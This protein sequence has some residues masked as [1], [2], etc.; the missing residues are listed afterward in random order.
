MKD[1][2][3]HRSYSKVQ[4]AI[5]VPTTLLSLGLAAPVMAQSGQNVVLEEIIVSARRQEESAQQIPIAITVVDQA[6]MSNN[7]V[8]SSVDLKQFTPSLATN[9][10]FGPDQA[11]FAIR[12][13][14]QELRTTA[15]VGFYFAEVVAPRGGGSVTA[16]DGAGPGAFFDLQNVLVLKGP[17]GTLFGRNTTGGAILLTPQEPT[18]QLEG[19]LEGSAGDYDMRRLQGVLNV[20]FSDTVRARFGVDTMQRDGYL[21][22]ISGVGPSDLGDTDYIS[23]RASVIWEITDDVEN[24]TILSYTDSENNG[25]VSSL[26]A[27]GTAMSGLMPSECNAQLARQGG[28]FYAVESLMPNPSSKLE[29]WQLINKTSWAINDDLTF[30]NIFSY[31]ELEQT[32][33]TSVFGIAFNY[34]NPGAGTGRYG[35]SESNQIPGGIPTNS[36]TSLVEEMQLQGY[37]MD[38]DLT[39]QAG[40]YFENSRPDGV[41]GSQSVNGL[42]CSEYDPTDPVSAICGTIYLNPL[43]AGGISRQAGK[44][45]YTTK[46]VYTEMTYDIT[47]ELKVTAGLRYTDDKVEGTVTDARV[48][49]GFPAY[50]GLGG[51]G[52]T[53]GPFGPIPAERCIYN[54]V[55]NPGPN[56]CTDELEQASEAVTGLIGVD[57]FVTQDAMLYAKYS[58]GY[59]M[60][61]LNMFGGE[62][63]RRFEPETVDAFEIGAKTT[64]GGPMPG[65]FNISAFYNELTDQQLQIGFLPLDGQTPT[66]GIQNAGKSVIQGVEVETMVMLLEDLALTLSYTYLDTQ[67]KEATPP[68]VP[69]FGP[70]AG[71]FPPGSRMTASG[72]AL[73]T[74]SS[75]VGEHL[76]FSPRHSVVAGLNYRLPLPVEIGD[77]SIGATYSYTDKQLT[78]APSSSPY[79]WLPSY[80]IVNLNANWRSIFGSNFDAGVFVTNAFDEEYVNYVAGLYNQGFENRVVGVP[81]MWGAKVRYNF[82]G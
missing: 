24:Y 1:K 18:N 74:S 81:K 25:T 26:F 72:D 3:S 11:T 53:P 37:A 12:G 82:G 39:W 44:I 48:Y 21:D 77:V 16:G 80:E 27:C 78:T 30:R 69:A 73:L 76:S 9:N 33:R 47:D 19:Y 66:T 13:F 7:N 17:Q 5:L 45:E 75:A 15:S 14:T 50:G 29:Q 79:A 64:F 20:P 65:T 59:R 54:N 49:G 4:Q 61:S 10:R 55:S 63:Y 58:R 38:G 51:A 70:L 8:F 42:Y 46:A 32:N 60:G 67:L 31:A 52:S 57:Y 34:P 71:I 68:G 23:A 56:D 35:F 2:K 28:D 41:S 36:Q 6:T 62:P 40:L 43:L 22:N